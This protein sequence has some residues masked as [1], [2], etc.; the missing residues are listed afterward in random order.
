MTTAARPS[1]D[2][3]PGQLPHL[4]FKDIVERLAA[5]KFPAG[6][7][8]VVAIAHDGILPGALVAQRLGLNLKTITISYRNSANEPQFAHPQ[9]VSSVPG[10][11]GWKRVLLVDDVWVTGSSWETARAHLPRSVEVLPFVLAGN[12]DFALL[13]TTAR[14]PQWPWN[15]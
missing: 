3:V 11:A 1:P 12:V 8:G 4:E 2:G 14:A 9:L 15:R 13:R 5:W 6:L 7:D 10:I